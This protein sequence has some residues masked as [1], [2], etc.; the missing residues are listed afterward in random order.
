V[1]F[2]VKALAVRKSAVE[3]IAIVYREEI[4]TFA[5]Q[6]SHKIKELS[7]AV[8]W[9]ASALKL[10]QGGERLTPPREKARQSVAALNFRE[11]R[12]LEAT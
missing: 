10:P 1:L 9:E 3:D 4:N 5:K 6:E 11:G 2:R 12:I 7:Q 8:F